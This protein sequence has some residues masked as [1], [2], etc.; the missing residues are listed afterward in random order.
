[1]LLAAI[2]AVLYI[3]NEKVVPKHCSCW[4]LPT[5]FKLN[6]PKEWLITC[7]EKFLKGASSLG[8][9]RVSFV[10]KLG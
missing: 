2:K 9:R 6:T 7:E 8:V 4:N 10:T 5:I 3:V 1:M